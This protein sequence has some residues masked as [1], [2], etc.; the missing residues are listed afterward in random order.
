MEQK[1]MKQC[2]ICEEWK[3]EGI[4]LLISFICSDCEKEI[5]D[6]DPQD[7]RYQYYIDRMKRSHVSSLL[8]Q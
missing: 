8:I 1:S 7:E 3:N 5:L 2:K 4:Y 6:T